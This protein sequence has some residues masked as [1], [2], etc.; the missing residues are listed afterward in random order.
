MTRMVHKALHTLGAQA[1]GTL[2]AI[3]L[4]IVIARVLGPTGRGIT[5]YAWLV[6]GFAAIYA[7]GPA[8]AVVTQYA[9]DRYA[10]ADV[11]R[12][13]LRALAVLVIPA[14]AAFLLVGLFVPGQSPLVAVAAALPFA[15]YA[16]CV[17]GFFLAESRIPTAN[18]VDLSAIGGYAVAG[19]LVVLLG[20]GILGALVTWVIAYAASALYATL[21]VGQAPALAASTRHGQLGTIAREQLIFGGKSGF[22]YA[23]GYLNLRM[24]AF[25]VA[26]MLGAAA[27]GVYTIVI[28][29]CELLWKISN[30]LAWSALGRIATDSDADLRRM[31]GRVTRTIVLIEVVLAVGLFVAGPW[32]IERVYGHAFAAAGLPLRVMVLGIAAYAI[33]PVLGYFMLVRLKKPVLIFAIQIASAGVCAAI[34]AIAIPAYGIAGAA[35]ATALTYSAVVLV[36]T[37]IVA[38]ALRVPI[39]ELIVPRVDDARAAIDELAHVMQRRAASGEAAA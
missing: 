26:A 39:L 6:L 19:T 37:V 34:A 8:A 1:L 14:A 31:L 11:F 3:V 30:A 17:K 2:G 20:G 7:D 38:R 9:T 16:Q 4:G 13:M 12:A 27:L 10:R 36:K 15:V 5:A 28:S 23:A 25:V 35:A 32:L 29:V 33:E 21:H 24:G 22:V 18:M